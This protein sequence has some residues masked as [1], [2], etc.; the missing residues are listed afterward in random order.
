L[1]YKFTEEE[2]NEHYKELTYTFRPLFITFTI[3]FKAFQ[4]IT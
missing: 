3:Y 4:R 2:K 1:T